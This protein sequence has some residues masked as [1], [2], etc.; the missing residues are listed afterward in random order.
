M[1]GIIFSGIVVALIFQT[2]VCFRTLVSGATAAAVLSKAG[3]DKFLVFFRCMG[4]AEM[5]VD[6]QATVRTFIQK[7]LVNLILRNEHFALTPKVR[8]CGKVP[9]RVWQAVENDADTVGVVL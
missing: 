6:R 2:F 7:V 9:L 3:F 4:I 5:G 8:L 1:D